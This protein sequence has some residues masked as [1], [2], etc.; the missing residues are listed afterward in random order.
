MKLRLIATIQNFTIQD[1]FKAFPSLELIV[2]RYKKDSRGLTGPAWDAEYNCFK[3]KVSMIVGNHSKQD[4]FNS[5]LAYDLVIAYATGSEPQPK[6]LIM[7]YKPDPLP[8]R[9]TDMFGNH[10]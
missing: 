4:T 6:K 1:L 9:K 2:E 10:Y 3:N 5:S 8:E 7:D